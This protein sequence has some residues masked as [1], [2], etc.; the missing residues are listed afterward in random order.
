MSMS[1]IVQNPNW[2]PH[3]RF[4]NGQT[5]SLGVCLF[6]ATT[7]LLVRPAP[8]K[9]AAKDNVWLAALVGTMYTVAALS[10][11]FYPGVSLH[12]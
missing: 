3:A 9:E 6:A 12:Y 5:M 4:H 8:S 2:P 11:I 7:Y 10:A 1:L